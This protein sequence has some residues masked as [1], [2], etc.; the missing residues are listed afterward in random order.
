MGDSPTPPPESSSRGMVRLCP[1]DD[2]VPGEARRF[3]VGAHRIAV[4]R[5]QDE[6]HAIGDRCTH[7]DV[8][9][10]EGEVFADDAEIECFKHGS[11]FSL[12]TGRPLCLPAT[13]P[14]PVYRVEIVDRDVYV[15]LD[16]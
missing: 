16:A 4:V 7:G 13:R 12:V 6:V 5:I 11:I 9:L 15:E 14:T 10:S 3:D 2:L 8:S 1:L